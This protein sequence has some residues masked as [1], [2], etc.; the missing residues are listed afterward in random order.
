MEEASPLLQLSSIINA[1]AP[2]ASG[3]GSTTQYCKILPGPVF[4]RLH[5]VD[6][7][8]N[9]INHPQSFQWS[10]ANTISTRIATE[11]IQDKRTRE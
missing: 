6:A 7:L 1:P 2:V 3:T 4:S 10:S 8:A 11:I 5:K 9:P